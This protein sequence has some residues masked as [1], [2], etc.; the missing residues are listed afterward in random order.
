MRVIISDAC[1]NAGKRMAHEDDTDIP[2]LTDAVR[3]RTQGELSRE[4]IDEL[5]DGLA[6]ATWVML[7]R[8][9]A[10]A[11]ADIEEQLRLNI[12]DRLGDELPALIEK[13][14]REKLAGDDR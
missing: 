9:I 11:M 13:T 10:E 14:L 5:C 12:N 3:R 2:I 7:D 1:S 8:L 4:Q 6:A